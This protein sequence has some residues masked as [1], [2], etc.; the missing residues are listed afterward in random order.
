MNTKTKGHGPQK[1]KPRE[2]EG[3]GKPF[4]LANER[5][6]GTPLKKTTHKSARYEAATSGIFRYCSNGKCIMNLCVRVMMPRHVTIM[7]TVC[8]HYCESSSMQQTY[9]RMLTNWNWQWEKLVLGCHDKN[10]TYFNF[11]AEILGNEPCHLQR[12][13]W[14]QTCPNVRL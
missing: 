10:P 3:S 12:P 4:Y 13:V 5:N 7:I 8:Q 1:L 11:P 9:P 6:F 2:T 14:K